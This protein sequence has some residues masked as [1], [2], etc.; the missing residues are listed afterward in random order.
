MNQ[1]SFRKWQKHTVVC[2][3]K[4]NKPT[5]KHNIT[6]LGISFKYKIETTPALILLFFCIYTGQSSCSPEM[7]NSCFLKTEEYKSKV[8]DSLISQITTK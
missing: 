8:F 7:V 3:V 4:K 2:R 5:Y 1:D 6:A